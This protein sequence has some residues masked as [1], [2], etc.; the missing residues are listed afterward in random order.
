MLALP[1]DQTSGIP[2][3]HL[4]NRPAPPISTRPFPDTLT[5]RAREDRGPHK[6]ASPVFI[7]PTPPKVG[8]QSLRWGRKLL[9]VG[10]AYLS[11]KLSAS[12]TTIRTTPS[13][14]SSSLFRQ[15]IPTVSQAASRSIPRSPFF[16]KYPSRRQLAAGALLVDRFSTGTAPGAPNE[17]MTP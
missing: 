6:R 1:F 7:A 4:S 15:E 9:L 16:S 13:G 2:G 17:G 14:R 8:R 11:L 5:R 3:P 12:A 10:E